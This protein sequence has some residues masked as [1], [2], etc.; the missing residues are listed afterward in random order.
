M[1]LPQYYDEMVVYEI[2]SVSIMDLCKIQL[3]LFESELTR[4]TLVAIVEFLCKNEVYN[5]KKQENPLP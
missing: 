2:I 4:K 3:S 1:F 5:K